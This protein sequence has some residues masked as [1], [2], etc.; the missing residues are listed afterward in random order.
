MYSK[1]VKAEDLVEWKNNTLTARSTRLTTI[2]VVYE[3]VKLVL[4]MKGIHKLYPQERP[5]EDALGQYT[6]FA[7]EMWEV[8][9]EGISSYAESLKD[10]SKIPGCARTKRP[11]RCCSSRPRRSR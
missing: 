1:S 5:D 4:A 8:L 10:P 9:L 6:E 3:T 7:Y 2:G 11:L